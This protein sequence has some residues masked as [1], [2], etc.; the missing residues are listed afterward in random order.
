M[1]IPNCTG[2]VCKDIYTKE[3][4]SCHKAS[5]D[6]RMSGLR[7]FM[8]GVMIGQ[9]PSTLTMKTEKNGIRLCMTALSLLREQST[10][11]VSV[12]KSLVLTLRKK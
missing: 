12:L 4:E 10:A 8:E 3:T 6:V 5:H 2:T 7:K 11:S 1:D 9:K